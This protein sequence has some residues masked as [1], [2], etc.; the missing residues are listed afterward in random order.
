MYTLPT[1]TTPHP[2]RQYGRHYDRAI[3]LAVGEIAALIVADLINISTDPD[4]EVAFPAR[5]RYAAE[6]Y[7]RHDTIRIMVHGLTNAELDRPFD[8][9]A[10][11]SPCPIDYPEIIEVVA[12]AYGWSN[13]GDPDDRRFL[14]R[15]VTLTEDEQTHDDDRLGEVRVYPHSVPPWLMTAA[16]AAPGFDGPADR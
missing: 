6:A 2:A 8:T 15:V 12:N 5:I 13:P 11:G 3:N 4:P 9:P 14:V 16:P 10:D 7:P 1:D